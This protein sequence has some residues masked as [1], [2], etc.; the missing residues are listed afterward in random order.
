MYD[1]LSLGDFTC[2]N[3]NYEALE[4]WSNPLSVDITRS[5]MKFHY[6]YFLSVKFI[7]IL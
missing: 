7:M 4:I 5:L 1:T 2:L 6:Q 3:V